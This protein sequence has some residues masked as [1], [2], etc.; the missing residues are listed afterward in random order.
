[1]VQSLLDDK[2]FKTVVA[3]T[4]LVS[5]DFIVFNSDGQILL[6]K[7]INRPAKNFWFVPG[8]RIYKDET[9]Q[10]AFCRLVKS[11][12]GQD[13]S[14]DNAKFLGHYQHF[15][16]DNFSGSDFS[17]HYVVLGYELRIDLNLYLLPTEQHSIYRW[18]DI[19]ELLKSNDV[20]ENTKAY[21]LNGY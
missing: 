19:S 1:M 18:W 9:F 15:Y 6:G 7:R 20:H 10:Q 12:L 13:C 8:G 14:I 11:E 5:L 2:T 21:L 4:P 17:T 16:K 3:S